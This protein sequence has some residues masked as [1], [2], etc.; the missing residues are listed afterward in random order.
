[1]G[2]SSGICAASSWSPSGSLSLKSAASGQPGTSR[3][4]T[5]RTSPTSLVMPAPAS[6]ASLT[7][8]FRRGKDRLTRRAHP[9]DERD[10]GSGQD[11][12]EQA[13]GAERSGEVARPAGRDGP[14][15]GAEEA[16]AVAPAERG[17]EV[18][19]A[20]HAAEQRI[21]RAPDRPAEERGQEHEDDERRDRSLRNDRGHGE[22]RQRQRREPGHD[23]RLRLEAPPGEAVVSEDAHDHA[24]GRRDA[25]ERRVVVRA[26]YVVHCG[27]LEEQGRPRR[28]DE[29][30]GDGAETR[31][32]E[33]PERTVREEASKAPAERLLRE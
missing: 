13:A 24:E 16:D 3:T 1:M 27:L 26:A 20:H 32:R 5:A 18:L 22:H 6:G 28:Q 29:L 33:E 23:D 9:A 17:A 2:L 21:D 31:Q 19:R 11:G 25:P 4:T 8:T 15:D 12:R 7:A 14:D 30:I 10:T